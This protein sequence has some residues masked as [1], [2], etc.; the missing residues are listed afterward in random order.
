[1]WDKLFWKD[2]VE[3][4]FFTALQV[5]LALL[6]VD[7]FDLATFDLQAGA[8]AVAVAVLGVLVKSAI[9]A[10]KTNSLSPASFAPVDK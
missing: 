4:S 9:A 7:G 3:R 2:A 6:T 1:M 10:G 5:V 8:V